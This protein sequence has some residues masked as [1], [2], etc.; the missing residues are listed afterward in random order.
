MILKAIINFDSLFVVS[1]TNINYGF[2]FLNHFDFFYSKATTNYV[3]MMK[4]KEEDTITFK[5]FIYTVNLSNYLIYL[6][7]PFK[8]Q[9]ATVMKRLLAVLLIKVMISISCDDWLHSDSRQPLII[10]AFTL[11]F[12]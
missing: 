3:V 12:H 1:Y 6:I 10:V 4:S 8:F 5:D 11:L 9:R 2:C 7:Y